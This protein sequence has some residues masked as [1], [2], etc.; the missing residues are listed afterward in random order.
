MGGI[1]LSTVLNLIGGVP[2]IGTPAA[3]FIAGKLV[4][5]Q[6]TVAGVGNFVKN[7][8]SALSNPL[9][10][11]T[12]ALS[13]AAGAA[14]DAISS[15]PSLQGLAGM[16]PEAQ[17]LVDSIQGGFSDALGSLG[18]LTDRLSG[19]ALPNLDVGQFGLN[20]ALGGID[21]LQKNF[22]E[23]MPP[24]LGLNLDHLTAPLDMAGQLTSFHDTVSGLSDS[25]TQAIADGATPAAAA[26]AAQSTIDSM[27]SV[28]GSAV[29]DCHAAYSTM[30][31]VVEQIGSASMLGTATKFGSDAA[32]AYSDKI[33]TT[34]GKSLL[35]G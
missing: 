32:Q 21:L 7:I 24:E 23:I 10:A 30:S 14:A 35:A 4:T 2:Q 9:G 18:G 19:I 27:S 34:M 5:V 25:I 1:G 29:A 3:T 28:M 15:L 22:G 16:I 33:L 12:S 26:L 6:N 11:V 8:T 31:N 17:G 20:Q 13:T